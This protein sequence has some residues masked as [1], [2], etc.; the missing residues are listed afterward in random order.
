MIILCGFCQKHMAVHAALTFEWNLLGIES[1]VTSFASRHHLLIALPFTCMQEKGQDFFPVSHEVL[2]VFHCSNLSQNFLHE[3]AGLLWVHSNAWL[4][5]CCWE[6]KAWEH[7]A[8]AMCRTVGDMIVVNE[9]RVG[10]TAVQDNFKVQSRHLCLHACIE[11]CFLHSIFSWKSSSM[12]K[13]GCCKLCN[14]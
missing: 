6:C 9:S 7:I 3:Q 11:C 12:L 14:K 4:G 1:A 5:F 13:S 2:Y 10:K 8:L